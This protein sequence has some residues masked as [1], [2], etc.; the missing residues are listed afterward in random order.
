[1]FEIFLKEFIYIFNESAIYILFGFFLAGVLKVSIPTEKILKYLGGKNT[2]SVLW[3]AILGIPLP[4]CSCAVLPTAM[5]LKRQGASKGS[6]LAFMISTPETGVDS[7]S[8]TYA[9]M[10]PIMTIFRPISALITAVSAGIVANIADKPEEKTPSQL[11]MLAPVEESCACNS[12]DSDDKETKPQG[13]FRS[14]LNYAFVEL[15]NDI[16]WWLIAGI[17]V[18]ALISTFIPVTFFDQHLD[19][20]FLSM[21]IMLVVGIPI[22]MC[23]A[24]ST[25]VAAALILKGLSPGAALVFLLAGPATNAG[26]I[27]AVGKFLGKKMMFIY[28]GTIAVVSI[29]LGI[30][31]NELYDILQ[32]NP[33]ASLGQASEL[34][35]QSLKITGSVILTGLIL[36]NIRKMGI[37]NSICYLKEKAREFTGIAK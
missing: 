37:K 6:T 20:G 12:C 14:I 31:L 5:S 13:K 16:A 3:A 10:D 8:I 11:S 1:M 15:L 27:A 32:I 36:N 21:L 22:Y 7:I 18:A 23:A 4:L 35:P 25:P 2:K 34:I 9:L 30:G 29:C 24:S 33:M 26:T 17:L 28:L 19:S